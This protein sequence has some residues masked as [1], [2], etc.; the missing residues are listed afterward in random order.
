ML[1]FALAAAFEQDELRAVL[2]REGGQLATFAAAVGTAIERAI[3]NDIL[4]FALSLSS[5]DRAG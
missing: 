4:A 1:C 2:T 3:S 5:T